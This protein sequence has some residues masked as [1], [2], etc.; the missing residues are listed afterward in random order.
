M[1]TITAIGQATALELSRQRLL[2]VPLIGFVLSMLLL[3]GALLVSDGGYQLSAADARIAAWTLGAAAGAGATV[4]A[5]IIGASL[6]ARELSAGTMLMLAA[7]PISRWQVIAGRLLG[8]GAFVLAM[9]IGV[10][11]AYGLVASL[12]VGAI[13]PLFAPLHTLVFSTPAVLLGLTLG[14]ACS[15]QGR[16][17]AAIGTA[18]AVSLFAL[19]VSAHAT[20]WMKERHLRSYLVADVRDELR[21]NS[22]IVG[23]GSLLVARAVPFGTFLEYASMDSTI[24]AVVPEAGFDDRP[25]SIDVTDPGYMMGWFQPLPASGE[26]DPQ[27]PS[28]PAPLPEQ[29]D[30]RVYD[31][32]RWN[33]AACFFGYRGAWTR[34]TLPPEP[35][36][37]DRSGLIVGWLAIPVW[38]AIAALLLWRRRDLVA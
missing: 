32:A 13:A 12:L 36:L 21:S 38:A 34:Q 35:T 2:L 26:G 30:E 33:G 37:A 6:I 25:G 15:V 16:A 29:P 18:V 28:E 24:A 27:R 3:I 7:R 11:L 14:I 9:L 5:T 8:A 4:Y 31:C 22:P 23:M 19:V 1:R 17:T 20:T 10:L